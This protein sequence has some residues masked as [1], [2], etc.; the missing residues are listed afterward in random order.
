MTKI[1]LGINAIIAAAAKDEVFTLC[2]IVVWI[3]AG[4]A[5][6]IFGN[7]GHKV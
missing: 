4:A 2:S 6:L 1:L 7:G 3:I 5:M